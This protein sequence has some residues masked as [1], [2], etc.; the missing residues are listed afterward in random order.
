[1]RP[2][3]ECPAHIS[4]PQISNLE[5]LRKLDVLD[6]HSNDIRDMEGF[7]ALQELRVLNLAGNKLR[8]DLLLAVV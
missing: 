3:P 2:S 1:M 4:C 8:F 5:S 6:L 7:D